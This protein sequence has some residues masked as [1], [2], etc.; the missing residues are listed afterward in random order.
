MPLSG[1]DNPDMGSDTRRRLA[2]HFSLV[3]VV[4]VLGACSAEVKGPSEE[5]A[6]DAGREYGEVILDTVGARTTVEEMETLC[7]KQAREEGI[8]TKGREGDETD[9]EIDAFIDACREAVNK[10]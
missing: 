6:R 8:V 9:N 4:A 7:G 5:E 3:L 2:R 10:K 1:C